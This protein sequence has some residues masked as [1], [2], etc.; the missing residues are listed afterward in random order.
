MVLT[1]LSDYIE[2]GPQQSRNQ[3][4]LS[5]IKFVMLDLLD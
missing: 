2:K 3:S 4:S 5:F 1:Q